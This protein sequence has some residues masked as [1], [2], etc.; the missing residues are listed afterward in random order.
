MTTYIY[1]PLDYSKAQIRLLTIPKSLDDAAPIRISLHTVSIPRSEL[2]APL[3]SVL[4]G[5]DLNAKQSDIEKPN[6]VALSYVWGPSNDPSQVLIES[7]PRGADTISI[8]RNLDVALRHIRRKS[9][10][11]SVFWIDAIC[12]DQGNIQERSNQVALMDSIYTIAG[13]TVV[14]LGP[15]E[16]KSNQ[17]MELL[18]KL[19]EMV[20][21]SSGGFL[22]RHPNAPPRKPGEPILESLK[23][24]LPYEEDEYDALISLLERPWFTR[25]WVRQEISLAVDAYV[26]CGRT[27]KDWIDFQNGAACFCK[28]WIGDW[29]SRDLT[30]RLR[31]AT[32][33]VLNVCNVN[34][35]TSS[36]ETLR[37]DFGGVKFTDP[38]DAIYGVRSLVNDQDQNL[39]VRP[40]YGLSTANVFTDVCVRISER[41][42]LTYFLD[43]C[44]FMSASVPDLPSWVPDW[45][46][47]MA[48]V[49]ETSGLWSACGFISAKA[50]YLGDGVLS[51]AGVEIDEIDSV[52]DLHDRSDNQLLLSIEATL[53]YIWMCYPGDE[54]DD[55]PY[56]NGRQSVTDAYCRT[57]ANPH[58]RD[59]PPVSANDNRQPFNEAKEALKKIWS[60]KEDYTGFEDLMLDPSVSRYLS[61]CNV[62]ARGR[63]FFITKK[64]YIGVA[65]IGT[66]PGDIV[67]VILGCHR[68]IIIRQAPVSN[69]KPGDTRW[70]VLGT[71]YTNG[72]MAGEAIYGDL[73]GHYRT[74][75][76]PEAADD[77]KICYFSYAFLDSRTN[78]VKTDPAAVLEE[79]GIKASVWVREPHRLEASE[80]V[81]RE[82]G[83]YLQDFLLV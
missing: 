46:K 16:G 26:L 17:A 61:N 47:P 41:Q 37:R 48:T 7:A 55:T 66:Q 51:V 3:E 42:G 59:G 80:S 63:C 79:F 12:I 21:Y 44:E 39:D 14:W 10:E 64:G 18:C 38:R 1:E 58:V 25:G 82:A 32:P 57:L 15:E 22:E 34:I 52:R 6:F 54:H 67:S 30:E 72:I 5:I 9:G 77:D 76:Y 62:T 70:K 33:A 4:E 29:A 73:P 20:E 36:Y 81:L 35:R 71:C 11:P 43:S 13:T 49:C 78:D 23:E 2:K 45:S 27:K 53:D 40:D 74:E 68:P 31:I 50:T 28:K 60:L 19:G 24:P 83:V 75:I 69:T 56:D 8:T 65:P